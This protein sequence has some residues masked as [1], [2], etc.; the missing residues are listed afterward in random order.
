MRIKAAV[1][2]V[3]G[4]LMIVPLLTGAL[5]GTLDRMHLPAVE[6]ALRATG[7]APVATPEGP[8]YEFLRI[9]G[10]TEALF[11]NGAVCL[12][13][14]FLVCVGSQMDF[15]TG[16][17]ALRKGAAITSAKFA[18][19]L[20]TAALMSALWDPFAGP[21]GLSAVAVIAAMS[22][23]NGGLYAALTGQYGNRSDVGGL[24]VVSLND[25][26]FFTL[27]GLWVLGSSGLLA[28]D[29][30]PA[31]AF[32]AVLVPVGLGLTLG[33]LDPEIRSF[34]APGE[35]LTVPFFAF[36]LGTGMDLR[37]FAGGPALAGGLLLGLA[38]TLIGGTC[39][40]IALRLTGERSQ[41]A[42]WAEASTAGN[43]VQTPYAVAL[44]AAAA[45]AAGLMPA[46][47]AELYQSVHEL[48][49]AQMSVATLTTALFCPTAVILWDRFQRSLGI[50]GR[51]GDGAGPTPSE[52]A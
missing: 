20:A 41:I 52:R 29:S 26:P 6:S 8:H 47:R 42:A 45:A 33:T 40:A 49:T 12:I 25:G 9:G 1:E 37:V 22:N 27:V 10:F 36:A 11:R 5:L 23:G 3:P 38:T 50:D 21:L 19:A 28:G 48:A 43:A 17:R 34:L 16:G 39:C 2:C 14:L 4:G 13:G 46:E 32:V 51:T 31:I 44:A 7:S 35:K 18:A 15:R 24:S 30:F